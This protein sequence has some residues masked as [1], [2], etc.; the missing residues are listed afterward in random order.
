MSG[1]LRSDVWNILGVYFRRGGGVVREGVGGEYSGLV[2][3]NGLR[4]NLLWVKHT[5]GAGLKGTQDSLGTGDVVVV[6]PLDWNV[7]WLRD[8]R[9]KALLLLLGDLLG[10]DAHGLFELRSRVR[11]LEAIRD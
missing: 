6:D 5:R 7:F 2:E 9:P 8:A 11:S 10:C 4:A 1:V 3:Q